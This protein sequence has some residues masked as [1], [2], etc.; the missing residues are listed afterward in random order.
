[1][2]TM[3][4]L[5]ADLRI[6]E[7]SAFV[8]APLGGMTMAQLGAEVIRIDP[9]KGGI[10]HHRWP[11][12]ASGASIYWAGL[13]KAKRSVALALD[14]AEG[15]ELA[16]AIATAPGPGA[17]IV[18]TNL[19]PLP[20]LDYASLKAARDDVIMLRLIGNRDGSAAVDY[21][22]NAASGFPLVTGPQGENGGTRPVNN[23]L[24]AWDVATGL[25]LSTAL[26]AAERHRTRAGA[27]QEVVA[28]LADVMLA[29]VGHLGYIGD[30][31]INGTSRPAL[32]N[33]LYGSFGRDFATAD[34]RRVMI[35]A[36]TPRQWRALGRATRL[37]DVLA[38]IGPRLG[39]DLDTEAGRFAA[40]D[41]IAEIVAPW[42][43]A[44]TLGEIET[45]FAGSGVLWGP[46]QNFATL[47]GADPR[48]STENPLFAE[49]DQ[50]GIG[51]YL[52]P[53][54]PLDF[55]A[56]P[57]Q[58]TGPAPVLGQHTAEV[59]SQVLGLTA[60]EIGRLHDAGIAAGPEA[61]EASGSN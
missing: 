1:M 17:G 15:R 10:D 18:L 24:P 47:V 9:L 48:C 58:P 8:A 30:V 57:R 50:P 23:V 31:Q 42:C 29:M 37:G 54:L 36:L 53:G 20:G 21:T 33:D 16:K 41:T 55:G 26:L 32:G 38:A 61:A 27:G 11:V 43:A 7:F 28:A 13:N 25:Y 51:R 46:F 2:A 60:A 45:A 52:A 12:T 6:V 49:I 14:K 44:R 56:A 34:G 59:L 39:V 35:I 3:N 40:R 22:V 4:N 19:P 5:L